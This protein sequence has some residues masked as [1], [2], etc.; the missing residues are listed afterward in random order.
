MVHARTRRGD[1]EFIEPNAVLRPKF[2]FENPIQTDI[3]EEIVEPVR[4]YSAT[5]PST[6]TQRQI[7]LSIPIGGQYTP[8]GGSA[9]LKTRYHTNLKNAGQLPNPDMQLLQGF[10]ITLDPRV[11]P[12][13]LARFMFQE[14]ITLQIGD[15]DVRYVELQPIFVP[16]AGGMFIAGTPANNAYASGN[17][18]PS[19]GNYYRLGQTE[20]EGAQLIEQG[21]SFALVEDPTQTDQGAFTT[22][23]TG[24]NPPSTVGLRVLYT[25]WGAR[26]RGVM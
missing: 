21:Q 7:L 20:Q 8:I 18:W 11:T 17:G 15:K 16:A 1:L 2:T 22:D 24:A 12:D 5:A 4:D 10:S 14:L 25:L 26:T 13:D 23:A 3:G 19:S 9:F 6:L